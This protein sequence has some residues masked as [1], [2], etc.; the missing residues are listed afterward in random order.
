MLLPSLNSVGSLVSV[1]EP[2]DTLPPK[3]REILPS[4]SQLSRTQSLAPASGCLSR[5]VA[6]CRS[7]TRFRLPS[8]TVRCHDH[9]CGSQDVQRGVPIPVQHQAA[10]RT[11]MGAHRQGFLD[12][13]ATARAVL[14]REAGRNSDNG[15]AMHLPIVADVRR[16]TAPNWHR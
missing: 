8:G 4:S 2:L 16:G 12:T 5:S 9:Q 3:G 6:F 14:C 10:G 11:H 15:D 1:E 13:K 7:R